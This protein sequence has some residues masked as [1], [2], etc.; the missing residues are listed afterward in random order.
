MSEHIL[1]CHCQPH[2]GDFV[3]YRFRQT[4]EDWSARS[5]ISWLVE[6]RV[7]VSSVGVSVAVVAGHFILLVVDVSV[8]WR[9]T[10]SVC[11]RP[12]RKKRPR[13][14]TLALDCRRETACLRVV[15]ELADR[16]SRRYEKES[17]TTNRDERRKERARGRERERESVARRKAFASLF[18]SCFFSLRLYVASRKLKLDV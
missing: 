6:T 17:E 1:A 13:G 2:P 12:L 5:E 15:P 8:R 10:V 7:S 4:L 11:R 3:P 14:T 9:R 18:P 16:V